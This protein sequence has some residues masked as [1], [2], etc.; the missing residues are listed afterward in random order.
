MRVSY[1]TPSCY[2]PLLAKLATEN[3]HQQNTRPFNITLGHQ[4]RD[5]HTWLTKVSSYKLTKQHEE[6]RTD[7][8]GHNDQHCEP[9]TLPHRSWTSGSNNSI[10]RMRRTGV[11]STPH[12][13]LWL[14][15][16]VE[17]KGSGPRR[18]G[19]TAGHRRFA[20]ACFASSLASLAASSG[21]KINRKGRKSGTLA[22]CSQSQQGKVLLLFAT[23]LQHIFTCAFRP[24]RRAVS[25][26]KIGVVSRLKVSMRGFTLTS[27]WCSL[28]LI[29]WGFFLDG[30]RSRIKGKR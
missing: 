19:Q 14:A 28:S 15:V 20:A 21:L 29:P 4:L 5:L 17:S 26:N 7:E 18:E 6:Q 16:L 8:C 2:S 27:G 30:Y 25:H 3:D 23:S 1:F 11:C 22:D 24:D 9:D 13:I 10:R 12:A